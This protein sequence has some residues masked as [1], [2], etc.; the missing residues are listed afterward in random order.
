M[1]RL[2]L[3]M[4]SGKKRRKQAVP[5]HGVPDPRLA[6]LKDEKRGDHSSERADD[7]DRSR[8]AARPEHFE[9]VGDRRICGFAG[10]EGGVLHHAEQ[11]DGDADVK[12]GADDKRGDDAEGQ[13]L[14]RIAGLFRGGGDGIESD[15]GEEDD[16]SAGD[17]AAE[18]RRREGMPVA[19]FTSAPPTTRKTR[20]APILMA[21]MMLLAFGGLAHAAHQQHG[22][23]ENDQ[24]SRES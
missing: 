12:N 2:E 23:N 18:T 3:G 11:H 17:D 7:D 24:E 14:L 10:N 19:G 8:P 20:M 4:N 13:I 5:R 1:R 6:V 9:S 15:V 22:E 16:G 21:T